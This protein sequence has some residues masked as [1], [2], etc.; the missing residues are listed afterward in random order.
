M[1]SN[2]TVITITTLAKQQKMSLFTKAFPKAYLSTDMEFNGIL[3]QSHLN[4]CKGSEVF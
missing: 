3:Q 2:I 4:F 1:S